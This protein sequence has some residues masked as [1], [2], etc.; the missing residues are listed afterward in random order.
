MR[1][2]RLTLLLLFSLFPATSVRAAEPAG[3]GPLDLEQAVE[4]AVKHH[5]ALQAQ[6][7]T[8]EARHAQVAV[9]RAGYLPNLDLSI[10][11]EA[12][13]GN[14]LRGALFPMR[15]IPNVSGP[16]TGRSLSDAAFGSVI[17]VG[18]GWDAIGLVRQMA[19]VDA[20]LADAAQT[21]ATT[22]VTRLLVAYAVADQ[23]IDVI[24]RAET[25][26]A[27]RVTV[28][29]MR[30]LQTIIK[31]LVD[32][33]LRPGADLSRANAELALAS[34][35]M[36]RAEQAE[37][38]SRTA[39]ARALGAA[40]E[41]LQLTPGRLLELAAA[42]PAAAAAKSPEVVEADA[43][44]RASQARKHA[45]D[46]QYLPR[47]DLLGA[48]WI[49]GSGLSSPSLGASPGAGIV[50]DTPNW[51]TGLCL[52]WPALELVAVRARSR[53]EAAQVKAAQARRTDV[54]QAVQSQIDAAREV[55]AASRR[56]AQNTPIAL[57]AARD[58]EAQATARYKAGLA[59]VDAV[60]EAER[61]L[62]QAEIDDAVARLNV[63][64]AEL[65]LARAVGDLAPFLT[66]LRGGR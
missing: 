32:Q 33:E 66:E 47:L 18:L 62:A 27:A 13:S 19:Q 31:A 50:P 1:R 24:S 53:V 7:A 65:L 6:L 48:L 25:V 36:I 54:M 15:D 11:I 17:G 12:G 8:D 4:Y 16:P 10:Q 23:F 63:R 9:G 46:L 57:Q 29:R 52:T 40:G 22:D 3:V 14:V 39:L 30:V 58:A 26:T 43:A 38:V 64:R 56:V 44:V 59:S 49:R 5:P 55:L 42:E 2:G 35:Q 60:A 34:T 21:R 28:D 61:L 37:A 51:A 45:I 20:L 41:R